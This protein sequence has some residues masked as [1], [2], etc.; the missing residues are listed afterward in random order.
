MTALG[1]NKIIC[2]VCQREFTEKEAEDQV[3]LMDPETGFAIC[4]ECNQEAL[5]QHFTEK[6]MRDPNAPLYTYQG[7]PMYAAKEAAVQAKKEAKFNEIIQNESPSKIK[8]HLDEYIIGQENAKRILSVAVYNHYKRIVYNNKMAQCQKNGQKISENAP[9]EVSKS[10]LVLLGPTGVGK[11]AI[12]E[13]IS[14]YLGVPF[15]ITD[16]NTLT[17]SGYVGL[18]PET[19]VKNLWLAAGKDPY[20]T[21]YGIIF[22][23]EFDKL[24][25]K[26][27]TNMMTT[28]DPGREGVQQALL[29]I[30]EGTVVNFAEMA[31]RRNPDAPG[32][33]IDTKN[34]LFIV[35]GAFEGID[36]IVESRINSGGA[37]GFHM[38]SEE[39][40]AE[41]IDA[42]ED[43]TD[44]FN[45]L[46]DRVTQ[47]D[48][49]EYGII[50][51]MMGRLPIICT[52]HQLKEDDLAR[53]LEEPKN[54]LIKQYQVLFGFDKCKLTFEKEAVREI[55]R[56]ALETK[57]GARALKT[58]MEGILLDIMYDLPDIVKKENKKMIVDITKHGMDDGNKFEIRK[59]A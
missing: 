57:T 2:S 13:A 28:S 32:I 54:A 51:E 41:N 58:I 37:F 14:K 30:I 40:D 19:C 31:G 50:P 52:L 3:V 23:D 20:K 38:N 29:K 4:Q 33:F 16:A 21:Q 25:R 42:I 59:A 7:D 46:I 18:D 56:K 53:I 10:N 44:R 43:E 1:N 22:I 35:G 9:E 26:S 27:G 17:E 6:L 39:K 12:L 55:A 49:K 8:A 5:N 48:I 34:I 47:D 11:T 24:A 45:A 15:A 36:K